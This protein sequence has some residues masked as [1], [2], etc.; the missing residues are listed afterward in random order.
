MKGKFVVAILTSSKALYK[1]WCWW[2]KSNKGRST[3]SHVLTKWWGKA[4]LVT[5]LCPET[6]ENTCTLIEHKLE[7][8]SLLCDLFV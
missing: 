2:C 5:S 8:D 7:L 6:S 1:V 3:Y 4:I